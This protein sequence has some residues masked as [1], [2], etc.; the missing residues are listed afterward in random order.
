M[1]EKLENTPCKCLKSAWIWLRKR[2]GNPV[3]VQLGRKFIFQQLFD[4][5]EG[6]RTVCAGLQHPNC[7]SIPTFNYPS[8]PR[9]LPYPTSPSI[10]LPGP[11]PRDDPGS[12]ARA[13]KW[14]HVGQWSLHIW[15][16]LFTLVLRP[17][18][19]RAPRP[20]TQNASPVVTEWWAPETVLYIICDMLNPPQKPVSHWGE[21]SKKLDVLEL[22]LGWMWMAALL[23]NSLKN[24]HI[25]LFYAL[26]S[27]AGR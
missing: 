27:G 22:E 4:T 7:H 11:D 20:H 17:L 6:K 24:T 2:Y 19:K 14:N 13:T 9:M 25:H 16:H 15:Q 10:C 1:L 18:I 12:C 21:K 23:V 26:R 5:K 3:Y 8:V